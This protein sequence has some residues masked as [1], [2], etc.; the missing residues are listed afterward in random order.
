[1]TSIDPELNQMIRRRGNMLKMIRQ[2]H[3][4]QLERMDDIDVWS[5]MQDIGA[6]M[7][8][9]QVVTMLQDLQVLGYVTFEQFFDED[10]E[11]VVVEKIMLTASGLGLVMR[12]K[13]TD[14]VRF[15]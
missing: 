1:M 12:R 10:R 8:Q 14:E 2:T 13:N 11:R 5:M 15:D 6:H 3:E 4:R 9:K 7:S